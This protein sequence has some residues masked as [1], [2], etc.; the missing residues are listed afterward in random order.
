[1]FGRGTVFVKLA[2][3]IFV[4][5]AVES[6]GDT[7]DDYFKE[8]VDDMK[9]RINGRGSKFDADVYDRFIKCFKK[10]NDTLL[11]ESQLSAWK[12]IADYW[13]TRDENVDYFGDP[14]P[15][16]QESPFQEAYTRSNQFFR[17]NN[18]V[19]MEPC[20]YVSNI[21]YYHGVLK[22]CDYAEDWSV[23]PQLQYDAVKAVSLMAVGSVFMHS[24]F[25]SVGSMLD[26]HMIGVIAYLSYQMSMMNIPNKSVMLQGLQLEERSKNITMVLDNLTRTIRDEPVKEWGRVL[27]TEDYPRD[28]YQSFA[29]ITVNLFAF[30]LPPWLST[31]L[32]TVMAEVLLR[33]FHEQRKWLLNDYLP[34]ILE[35]LKDLQV[36]IGERIN[37]SL[38]LAGV[39]LKLFY[40]FCYQEE[41]VPVPGFIGLLIMAI[42]FNYAF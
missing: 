10:F 32:L 28:Y 40:A 16:F 42:F 37:L 3:T 34:A 24:S 7:I 6:H 35:A 14:D 27:D 25:T 9:W 5:Y 11:Y 2:L 38:Q 21:A 23:E 31:L 17:H 36:P 19:V 13:E 18:L 41:H 8:G 30:T 29:A 39:L 20:N 26:K 4:T 33:N 12:G 1:M 15:W 22:L